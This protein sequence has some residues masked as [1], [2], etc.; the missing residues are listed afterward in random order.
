MERNNDEF[1]REGKEEIP[2]ENVSKGM[3]FGNKIL[4][5]CFDLGFDLGS[6]IEITRERNFCVFSNIFESISLN[7]YCETC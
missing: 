2:F 3:L 1:A 7:E 6:N 4:H 5:G